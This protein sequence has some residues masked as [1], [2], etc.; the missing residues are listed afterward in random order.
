MDEPAKH[1]VKIV[2][3]SSVV[4]A[5]LTGGSMLGVR[6]VERQAMADQQAEVQAQQQSIRTLER[7]DMQTKLHLA[8]IEGRMDALKERVDEDKIESAELRGQVQAL[9]RMT[10]EIRSTQ[11]QMRNDIDQLKDWRNGLSPALENDL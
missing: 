9:E 3:L 2:G 4:T 11:N 5:V 8:R 6:A 10:V 1:T 7:E